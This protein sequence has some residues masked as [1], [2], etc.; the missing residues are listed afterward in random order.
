ME[1]RTTTSWGE[2]RTF[3]IAT[4][5]KFTAMPAI[6]G[7]SSIAIAAI[8]KLGGMHF[9]SA[10]QLQRRY[11]YGCCRGGGDGVLL[12]SKD[13]TAALVFTLLAMSVRFGSDEL[14]RCWSWCKFIRP[15][16]CVRDQIGTRECSGCV[17][18]DSGTCFFQG[19]PS[20]RFDE[21]TALYPF[22][23]SKECAASA[24]E[25]EGLLEDSQASS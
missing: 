5:A 25:T 4:T 3:I 6:L 19:I 21:G 10:R 2:K 13:N 7:I 15:A 9:V 16:R 8:R 17:L 24:K 23:V 20:H 11:Q 1:A 18:Q 12:S 14:S 22:H